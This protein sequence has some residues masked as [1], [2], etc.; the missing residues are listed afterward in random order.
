MEENK[1]HHIHTHAPYNPEH[2]AQMDITVRR[3]INNRLWIYR[4][5]LRLGHKQVAYL[6]G[7][8]DVANISRWER[9]EILPSLTNALK[10]EFILG[11]PVRFLFHELSADIQQRVTSRRERMSP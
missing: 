3:R 2:A 5:K 4:H 9:G 7:I 10:L 6:M 11:V 1:Q 8:R